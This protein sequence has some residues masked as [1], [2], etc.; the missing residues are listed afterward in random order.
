MFIQ[1]NV[2]QYQFSIFFFWYAEKKKYLL[3]VEFCAIFS[4]DI[5]YAWDLFN[6]FFF[7]ILNIL[8][9]FFRISLLVAF[10]ND[11]RS[12]FH[13]YSISASN[14]WLESRKSFF[15]FGKNV[16]LQTLTKQPAKLHL[17]VRVDS[18]GPKW[19]NYRDCHILSNSQAAIRHWIP[20]SLL[21]SN[22]AI[23]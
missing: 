23:S 16:K 18:L 8:L 6:T 12:R 9:F 21:K 14:V 15:V 19:Q 11:E 4:W 1:P 5:I 22:F 20:T 13:L 2:C 10:I 3:R 17:V 7:Q